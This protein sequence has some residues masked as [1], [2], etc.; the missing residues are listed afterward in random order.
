[1]GFEPAPLRGRPSVLNA[2][3]YLNINKTLSV[4]LFSAI[5][6]RNDDLRFFIRMKNY[7]YINIFYD[8]DFPNL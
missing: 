1:M 5:I 7:T 8:R 3:P 2:K 4:F 6:S